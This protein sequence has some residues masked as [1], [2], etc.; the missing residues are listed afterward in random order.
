MIRRLLASLGDVL[1]RTRTPINSTELDQ[2]V[3]RHPAGKALRPGD[4]PPTS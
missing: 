3:S 4:P 1:L 2:A